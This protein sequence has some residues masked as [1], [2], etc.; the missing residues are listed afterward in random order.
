MRFVMVMVMV[1]LALTGCATTMAPPDPINITGLWTGSWQGH[2][3]FYIQREDVASARFLQRGD[4]AGSGRF[5][6]DGALASESVPFS[7]RMAGLDGVPVFFD[8]SGNTVTLRHQNGGEALAEFSV[9]GDR[10]IGYPLDTEY[11]ARIILDRVVAAAPPP[12]IAAPAPPPPPAPPTAA[13]A[14]PAVA[15]PVPPPPPRLPSP[16]EFAPTDA[17]KSVYFDFDRSEIRP[18]EIPV[19]EGNARWLQANREALLLIEGHC[20]ERGTDAYNLALGDRRAKAV[21]D[22]LVAQGVAADRITTLSYGE[23]RPV[24]TES[25]EACWQQNRRAVF[26]I[27]AQ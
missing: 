6:I 21:R 2:G 27:K 12:A 5:W 10:M 25:N 15:E 11:P 17:L 18:S 26:V 7:I 8:I 23:E 9:T 3:V 13:P 14:P 20:D 16:K 19:L 24:C 4:G 1:A 22:Y